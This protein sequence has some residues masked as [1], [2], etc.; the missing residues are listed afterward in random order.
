[1][2]MSITMTA[3]MITKRSDK[4]MRKTTP[5]LLANTEWIPPKKLLNEVQS[6]RMV[7][8]L[9]GLIKPELTEPKVG[10]AECLAY[11][12]AQ[13]GRSVPS[14]SWF[15]NVYLFLA[16][17]ILKRWKQFDALPEDCRVEKLNNY[18]EKNLEDLRYWIYKHRGG[19]YKNPVLDAIKEVFMENPNL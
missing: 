8:G 7:N 4:K 16:G 2:K 1:M 3:I 13:T 12:M 18:E 9:C 5:I 11:M 17:R 6:E 14:T 19:E 15:V 10:D